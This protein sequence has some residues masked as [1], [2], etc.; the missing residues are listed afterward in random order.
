MMI[1]NRVIA[2]ATG[3]M[4]GCG[5]SAQTVSTITEQLTTPWLGFGYNQ[6]G[7]ARQSDGVSFRPWD[8]KSWQETEQ[9]ILAIRP[10]LVRLP[11]MRE[12]FNKDDNGNPLPVGTYNWDS[13]EM[14]AFYKSMDLY[15]ANNIAVLSGLWHS[16]METGKEPEDFYMSSGEGSFARLQA[17]L[18]KYL[19]ETKGY[20]NIH[21]YT[22]T[23][24]P[25][26]SLS[27][28]DVW[29]KMIKNLHSELAWRDLPT[30][31]LIGA[32]SW[33]DWTWLPARE[34]KSELVGYDFH[35][36]LNDTP[37]DT[38][39]LLYER[40][41]E[42]SLTNQ[43]NRI[44]QEDS[45]NKPVM[46]TE[47]APIGVPFIDWPVADAP[48][49]CRVE[50]YEY[51]L[52]FWD[53]GIQ[54]MRAGIS[55]GLAWGL[56]G[57]DQNKNAGMWNSAGTY[58]GMTL[59]PW[60][61]TWQLMCRYFPAGA[62]ILKMSEM[63]GAKDLRIAGAEIGGSDYTFVAVNRRT[64]AA[65][66]PQEVTFSVPG[67]TKEFYVYTYSRDYYGDGVALTLPYRVVKSESTGS[68]TIKV[69]VP[70]EGGVL[71]TTLPPLEES[72]R[73]KATACNIDF[74]NNDGYS[75][76]GDIRYGLSIEA[77]QNPRKR[78]PNVS[79]QVCRITMT[80]PDYLV[81]NPNN[82]CVRIIPDSLILITSATKY[83]YFQ[84]YRSNYTTT[85]AFG[86][87]L[88]DDATFYAATLTSQNRQWEDWN[89]D[90]SAFAGKEIEQFVFYPNRD[91]YTQYRGTEEYTYLDRIELKSNAEQSLICN[92]MSEDEPFTPVNYLCHF[93]FEF[94]NYNTQPSFINPVPSAVFTRTV[95]PVKKDN[96][97]SDYAA[98]IVTTESYTPE[99]SLALALNPFAGITVAEN[100][101]VLHFQALRITNMSAVGIKIVFDGDQP[102]VYQEF[103]LSELRK[104]SDFG[105]DLSEY[106]GRVI[107]NIYLYPVPM[108]TG[109]PHNRLDECYFDNILLDNN[110]TN[111]ITQTPATNPY[112]IISDGGV[113]S[114]EGLSGENVSIFTLDGLNMDMC[115]AVHG[116]YKKELTP[117]IYLI[118]IDQIVK[119]VIIY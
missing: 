84:T 19:I 33:G 47:I 100:T 81:G 74:E 62:T 109:Q 119:K 25:L 6:W 52:G 89:I 67:V 69:T 107:Q 95:N 4:L 98:K 97:T 13:K 16:A 54:L 96:N 18:I 101:P 3:L 77:G 32:D 104:W 102:S 36:Y 37:D 64:C 57:F 83:L 43:L 70:L 85:V 42:K 11:L 105:I 46:I 66:A 23:N 8:D 38:Y 65:S 27:S 1:R 34:N 53:Y 7:Y 103:T 108:S 82:A 9:R 35:N 117:G 26:G 40:E 21:F 14:Q 115:T 5:L 28:Y 116:Q 114:V 112:V 30:D 91:Y 29:K 31:I 79:D 55:T 94:L 58:G 73:P 59:R 51:G 2:I 10:A 68:G 86:V 106:T 80:M 118:K 20:T 110:F 78:E 93:D 12:W 39:R 15:K 56:D 50:T 72:Q 111:S 22:P 44:R 92:P 49:H 48:A 113:L 99:N 87:K 61:Y 60:Y 88:K 75:L 24:E 90:L 17:D 45:S 63:P 41:L 76:V 71:V